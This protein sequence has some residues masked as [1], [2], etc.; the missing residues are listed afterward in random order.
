MATKEPNQ[1]GGRAAKKRPPYVKEYM[2]GKL[3]LVTAAFIAVFLLLFGRLVYLAVWK[4]DEY[5][6][7]VNNNYGYQTTSV[8]APRGEILD[9]NGGVLAT[10]LANYVLVIEPK[11]ILEKEYFRVVA[12][13]VFENVLGFDPEKLNGRLT[14]VEEA[15]KEKEM[16]DL[17]EKELSDEKKAIYN[18]RWYWRYPEYENENRTTV[19]GDIMRKVQDLAELFRST[20]RAD[21]IKAMTQLFLINEEQ[22][23]GI[24]ADVDEQRALLKKAKGNILTRI[25]DKIS[26]AKR[27]A[28]TIDY[29]GI[30]KKWSVDE[31]TVKGVA[32]MSVLRVVGIRFETEYERVYPN[33]TLAC[34]IL[35]FYSPYYPESSMGLERSYNSSL[36]GVDGIHKTYMTE[37]L[38]RDATNIEPVQGKTLVTGIDRYIQSIIE[39]QIKTFVDEIGAQ[40]VGVVCMNPQNGT[41]VAMADDR[42]YNP[43]KHD[44]LSGFYTQEQ[45]DRIWE[46]IL[47]SD[48]TMQKKLLGATE[49]EK[50]TLQTS[51]TLNYVYRN[52]CL[53]D[54]YEPGSAFK[55][56]T[57]AMGYELGLVDADTKFVCDGYADF[58]GTKVRCHNREGCGELDLTGA[59]ANSCN[60]Y[61]M[62][63]ASLVGRD[64]FFDYRCRFNIGSLTGVDLPGEVSAANLNFTADQLNPLELAT[65]SFGQGFNTTMMQMSAALCSTING[66]YYYVPHI[67]TEIR[68]AEGQ[69]L[70]RP[71][72]R[73][74]TQV[75]S[76]QTSDYLREAMYYVVEDG[77]ASYVKIAGYE[78]GGKTGTAQKGNYAENN[79]VISL[80]SF[81]PVAEPDLFLYVVIDQPNLEEQNSSKWAQLL[82]KRIWMEII[83]YLNLHSKEEG[84]DYLH[85]NESGEDPDPPKDGYDEDGFLTVDE[86]GE[87]LFR[88][89][90][91]AG[92]PEQTE[93]PAQPEQ[94]AQPEPPAQPDAP[95]PGGEERD[96]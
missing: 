92:Q 76:K 3:L 81:I 86:N 26:G 51:G 41:I 14:D 85:P 36:S 74:V 47:S 48:K 77:T 6:K 4:N 66:G 75:I 88:P 50:K 18:R 22:I 32:N 56:L 84:V 37:D 94:P 33:D 54:T 57:V 11:S 64:D 30:A 68:N 13:K 63:V 24:Q 91:E 70:E 93:A 79:Y 15:I 67:V 83:P 34:K 72:E 53:S 43:N 55:P 62:Y 40:N 8:P 49:E 12:L 5:I 87:Q 9:R 95:K 27:E 80:A 21:K 28:A 29:A 38:N 58:G 96:E 35:G 89:G 71:F 39:K 31:L 69:I 1:Q 16:A 25:L 46:N 82:S 90:E 20:K 42:V 78:I 52:F 2:E 10:S 17:L 7:N 19:D 23:E 44:D 59:L 73:P 65:S 61:L 60:D 45:L